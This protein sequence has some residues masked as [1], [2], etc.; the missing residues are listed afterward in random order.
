M[1]TDDKRDEIRR[2]RNKPWYVKCPWFERE[3]GVSLIEIDRLRQALSDWQKPFIKKLLPT[4]TYD[5]TP[6]C[7]ID[8]IE[9]HTKEDIKRKV[10]ALRR[11][12]ILP[13]YV[14]RIEV[15]HAV[16]SVGGKL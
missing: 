1:N 2:Q 14:C 12:V 11:S 15:L 3:L 16:D 9:Q 13:L 6:R 7:C 4:M 10:I 5:S 8:Q